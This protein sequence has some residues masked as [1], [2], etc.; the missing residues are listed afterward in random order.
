MRYLLLSLIAS[1]AVAR[2]QQQP[3]APVTPPPSAV[4]VSAGDIT[5]EILWYLPKDVPTAGFRVMQRRQYV[6]DEHARSCRI[7]F[8][9]RSDS[10]FLLMLDTVP[11]PEG[12]HEYR[13]IPLDEAGGEGTASAWVTVQTLHDELR[14]YAHGVSA[15]SDPGERTI[16]LSWRMARP[17]RVRGIRIF[18]ADDYDGPYAL[19]AE[20]APTDTLLVDAVQ[21]VNEDLFYRVQVVDVFGPGALSVPVLAL[22]DHRPTCM[23]PTLLDAMA[24]A[25]GV[26]VTWEPRG[27][28]IMGFIV[29]RK[30]GSDRDW[31]DVSGLLVG[32]TLHQWV[33]REVPAR[34][35]H[36][37]RVVAVSTGE[38]RSEASHFILA[39]R[40]AADGPPPPDD[41]VAR[42]PGMDAVTVSWRPP[43]LSDAI[44]AGY[45]VERSS[46]GAATFTRLNESL[47]EE[48]AY[49]FV[50]ST[51]APALL[52]Q[53]RV[54]SVDPSG[55]MGSPTGAVAVEGLTG[56][57]VP[58]QLIARSTPKGVALEWPLADRDVR[59]LRVYR[60]DGTSTP[61]RLCEL[62]PHA[63]GWLDEKPQKGA[64][65]FYLVRAVMPDGTEGD[66]SAPV[67]VR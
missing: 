60:T 5:P 2:A 57:G 49:R 39:T 9:S 63:T 12:V 47:I 54:R 55:V 4:R 38:L 27:T 24:G 37:W 33:D 3:A 11:V 62:P 45:I 16:K 32:D 23:P 13:L 1:A 53:Y 14:P 52:L 46:D 66:V 7:L 10:L 43:R 30:E 42:R 50:D 6:G 22:S 17:E 8:Q 21:R 58:R 20:R 48:G 51:A 65:R 26:R 35:V 29:Q 40:P 31:L 44:I 67:A 28:D 56:R 59:S 41:V 34:R 15:R 19:I 18:R 64:T 61:T 25:D 36:A